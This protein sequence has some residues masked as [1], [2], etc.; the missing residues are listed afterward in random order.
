MY[1]NILLGSGSGNGVIES[2]AIELDL[3]VIEFVVWKDV[4][5]GDY[6]VESRKN[7]VSE[8]SSDID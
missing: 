8:R 4:W 3:D 1:R 5:G 7:M 2:V 6:L